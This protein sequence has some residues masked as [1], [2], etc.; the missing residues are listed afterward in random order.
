[1]L[2]IGLNAYHGDASAAALVD[3][4]LVAAAEEERFSRVKHTAGFPAQALRYVTAAA[5]ASARDVQL[6]AVARD[7][8]ARIVPKALCALR[9]PALALTRVNVQGKFA[10][11]STEVARVLEIEGSVAEVRRIEHHKAHLASSFFVSPFDEAALFSVDGMGDFASTMWGV[12]RGNRIFPMGEVGFPHSLGIFYTALSQ[13][14]GFSRYGDE[15]K[16]M[17][18][19]SYGEPEFIEQMRQM[20][21]TTDDDSMEFRLDP[22]C[23][24]HHKSGAEMTWGCGEPR[25]GQLFAGRPATRAKRFRRAIAIS[26][27]PCNGAWRKW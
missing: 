17:A 1:M 19:A 20:V 15:Y 2:I 27:R 16:V 8:W 21:V 18:L 7:P 5:G 9:M 3:G 14:L 10:G 24:V 4:H 26:R 13:Y 11:I 23:F 6:V 22:A 12:G 25:L